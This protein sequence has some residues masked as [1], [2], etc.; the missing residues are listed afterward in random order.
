MRHRKIKKFKEKT[1]QDL[2]L[3]IED[4][5][6]TLSKSQFYQQLKDT[7][8]DSLSSSIRSSL[9]DIVCYGIGSIKDSRIT[10]FQ[11]SLL[12]LLRDLFQA[13]S[14][15]FEVLVYYGIISIEENEKAKRKITQPTLFYMPHC[16]IGLYNNLIG[17]NWQRYSLTNMLL[18]GNRLEFYAERSTDNTL[19]PDETFNETCWHWFP[20]SKIL[21]RCG[22]N[23]VDGNDD[24]E[25]WRS[26]WTNHTEEADDPEII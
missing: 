8:Q 3:N 4:K 26:K 25:F 19:W 18:I 13:T 10:Q 23:I 5:K 15:D 12:L 1:A 9:V 6:T 14:L 22:K 2:I 24:E 20:A 16:P 21:A 7:I 11:F 17:A